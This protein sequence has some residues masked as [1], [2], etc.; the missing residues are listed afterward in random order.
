MSGGGD[1]GQG[2]ILMPTPG[3][4]VLCCPPAALAP[5]HRLLVD[6]ELRGAR[7]GAV[8]APALRIFKETLRAAAMSVRGHAIATAADTCA[9]SE[10]EGESPFL[11][12]REVA[13]LL[14][15][16]LR[17]VVRITT[18]AGVHKIARDTWART[19]VQALLTT[20]RQH[21]AAPRRNERPQ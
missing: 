2:V 14:G 8:L 15:V 1:A 19:D 21:S 6:L 11:T 10:Q 16:D 5:L 17:S 12:S 9:P 13:R 18:A 7:D 4:I 20:R 3:D